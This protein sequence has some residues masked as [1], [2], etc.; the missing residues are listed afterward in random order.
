MGLLANPVMRSQLSG[1]HSCLA[2]VTHVKVAQDVCFKMTQ[3]ILAMAFLK[4]ASHTVACVLPLHTCYSPKAR[5]CVIVCMPADTSVIE[6]LKVMCYSLSAR[7][8][9]WT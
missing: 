5:A 4:L 7:W 6:C 2:G 3:L 1:S 8:Y 9:G